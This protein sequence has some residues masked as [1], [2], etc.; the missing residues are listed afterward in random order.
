MDLLNKIRGIATEANDYI[1][2]TEDVIYVKDANGQ[3]TL[4]EGIADDNSTEGQ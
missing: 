4:M 3:L 2:Q 1:A